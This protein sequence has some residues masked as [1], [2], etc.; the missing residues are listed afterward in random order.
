MSYIHTIPLTTEYNKYLF[1]EMN[2]LTISTIFLINCMLVLAVDS[3]RV[4]IEFNEVEINFLIDTASLMQVLRNPN[5]EEE[6]NQR[7]EEIR[8][9]DVTIKWVLWEI[10]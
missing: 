1:T 2:W 5:W 8:K 6:A 7:I 10:V 3:A 4:Y 9:E